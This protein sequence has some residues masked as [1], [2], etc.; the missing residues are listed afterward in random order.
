MNTR[1]EKCFAFL[2]EDSFIKP[3]TLADAS[4][5][6]LMQFVHIA[7]AANESIRHKLMDKSVLY[8]KKQLLLCMCKI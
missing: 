6:S 3:D 5:F 4:K 1:D 8:C 2:S 7:K